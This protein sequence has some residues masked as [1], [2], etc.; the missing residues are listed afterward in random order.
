MNKAAKIPKRPIL[1]LKTFTPAAPEPKRAPPPLVETLA[2][3]KPRVSLTGR[4]QKW[5]Q[6]VVEMFAGTLPPD[7]REA[8]IKWALVDQQPFT[9]AAFND[10]MG[11]EDVIAG[12]ATLWRWRRETPGARP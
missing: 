5:I 11:E 2:A 10:H 4:K 6:R 3:R 12:L 7:E 1:H 8:A 9:R